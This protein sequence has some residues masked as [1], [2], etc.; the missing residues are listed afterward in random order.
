MFLPF[1]E[2]LHFIFFSRALRDFVTSAR[3]RNNNNTMRQYKKTIFFSIVSSLVN[4]FYCCDDDDV[5]ALCLFSLTWL[6]RFFRHDEIFHKEC[7][8]I[9]KSIIVFRNTFVCWFL[10]NGNIHHPFSIVSVPFLSGALTLWNWFSI[11]DAAI[12]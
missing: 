10:I 4:F 9:W 2:H 7:K 8:K 3:E 12:N 11:I 1:G 5:V 6:S